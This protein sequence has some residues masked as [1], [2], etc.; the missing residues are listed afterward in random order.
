MTQAPYTRSTEPFEM[1]KNT[2]YYVGDNEVSSYIFKAD[3]GTPND[4]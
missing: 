4:P 3:M 1:V 2:M